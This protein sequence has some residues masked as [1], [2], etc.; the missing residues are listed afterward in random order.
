[1]PHKRFKPNNKPLPLLKIF[2]EGEKTEPNYIAGYLNDMT[3]QSRRSLIRIQ[4]NDKNTPVQLVDE[5]IKEKNKPTSLNEDQIWVVYDRESIA[6]YKEKLHT[7]A[8]KK[9]EINNINIALSNVCFE[10]WLLLHIKDTTAPYGS[11]SDLK[12]KSEFFEEFKKIFP[13]GYEKSSRSIFTLLKHG[14]GD[15]RRRAK[16]LNLDGVT[17]APPG[18]SYPHQINPFMGMVCLL[19][20]IDKFK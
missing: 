14:L 16:R 11:F 9:A 8:L 1:M 20:A 13:L 17:S 12:S 6:K 4:I 18:K 3:D 10:Y 2:C 7:E 15:A 5:A 19:D